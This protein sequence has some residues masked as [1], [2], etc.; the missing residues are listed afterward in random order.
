MNAKVL[1]QVIRSKNLNDC[2][3]YIHNQYKFNNGKG[4]VEEFSSL[5]TEK[6]LTGF[7][8]IGVFSFILPE[9]KCFDQ[10][11]TEIFK[12]SVQSE[13]KIDTL[14]R[15]DHDLFNVV[16]SENNEFVEVLGKEDK[17]GEYKVAQLKNPYKYLAANVNSLV[18]IPFIIDVLKTEELNVA[19][20][21][22]YFRIASQVLNKF[23]DDYRTVVGMPWISVPHYSFSSFGWAL[24]RE[25]DEQGNLLNTNKFLLNPAKIRPSEKPYVLDD[26]GVVKNKLESLLLNKNSEEEPIV[27]FKKGQSYFGHGEYLIAIRYCVSAIEALLK[28]WVD[29][30]GILF[31]EKK[32]NHITIKDLRGKFEEVLKK[33]KLVNDPQTFMDQVREAIQLRHDIEHKSLYKI[34]HT[35]IEKAIYDLEKFF[36]V[37]SEQL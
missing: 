26:E 13:F 2:I 24:F 21:K 34:S 6:F 25:Y 11:D 8:K 28:K 3:S 10:V 20:R 7:S 17:I 37:I 5:K 15:F 23:S 30:K 29:E 4:I 31:P 12:I 32:Q 22:C 14:I 9:Y 33:E 27:M 18:S 35:K 1:E 36:N 19:L 16:Y